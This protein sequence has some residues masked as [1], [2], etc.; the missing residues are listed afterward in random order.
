MKTLKHIVL[1]ALMLTALNGYSTEIEIV[2]SASVTTLQFSNVKK[3]Q[4]ITIKDNSNITLYKEVVAGNGTYAKRFDL[5]ALENGTYFIELSKDCEII[6]K[7]FTI[8]GNRVRFIQD[9]EYKIFKP[10][11]RLD[12]EH[13]IVSQLS[14][15]NAPLNVELYYNGVLIHTDI[16]TGATILNRVYQLSAS[17]KGAYTVVMNTGDRNFV[18]NFTI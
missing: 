16:I 12:N 4:Q 13:L 11:V 9:S 3:G 10:T 14:L 8:Q 17:Q 15:T 1:T 6:V 5:T 2:S 18:Q 7:S